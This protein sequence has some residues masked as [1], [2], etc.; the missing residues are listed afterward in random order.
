MPQG[1]LTYSLAEHAETTADFT[2]VAFRLRQGL[3]FHDGQ[4]LTTADVASGPMKTTRGSVPSCSGTSW[5]AADRIQS[6]DDRTIVFHF[7][8]PFLEFMDLYTVVEAPASVGLSQALL[9]EGGAGWL[10]GAAD[11]GWAL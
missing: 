10:Q 1:E 2:K 3:K 11:R 9:R 6:V 5:I 8:E 4:P 7:K